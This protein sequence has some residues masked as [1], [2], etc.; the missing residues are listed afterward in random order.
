MRTIVEQF[1]KK[2]KKK[3]KKQSN[4]KTNQNMITSKFFKE[5]LEKKKN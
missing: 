4:A 5:N 2:G 3:K 1:D